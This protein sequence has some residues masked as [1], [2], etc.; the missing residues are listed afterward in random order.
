[1]TRCGSVATLAGGETVLGRGNGGADANLIGP[2]NKKIHAF[3]SVAT[4]RW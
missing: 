2:K 3:D 1:V 4:N